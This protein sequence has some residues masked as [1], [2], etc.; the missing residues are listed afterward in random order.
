VPSGSRPGSPLVRRPGSPPRCVRRPGA[1]L[2]AL[3]VLL[4][5][6]TATPLGAQQPA[7]A[8]QPRAPQTPRAAAPI[9]L[10]GTWVSVVT[11]D[12]RWRMVLPRKGD[13]SSVPLNPQGRKVADAWDPARMDGDGCRP[14]GAAAVMRIP[15]R[16]RV[17]WENDTTLRIETDAGQQTRRLRFDRPLPPPGVRSWQ[18]QSAAEW[19]RIVQPGGLG[20]SLAQAPA[21]TGTLKV[22]TTGL[23]A[24]YLRRNGVPYSEN[25]AVTEYYDRVTEDG[26]DWL[27]V[28]TVVEDP[29]YLTQPF[30]TSTHFRREPDASKWKPTPCERER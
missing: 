11:E 5:G 21:R 18:G 12:W 9:D 3:L 6:T 26:V 13:Y 30:I 28:I 19:E 29:Q 20:V 23:R 4:V 15:G 1:W 17:S 8:A 2:S 22:V 14:F 7:G 27:T 10:T 16:V 24:G 25:A